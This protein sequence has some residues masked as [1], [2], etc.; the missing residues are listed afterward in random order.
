MMDSNGDVF[1]NCPFDHAYNPLFD[2][3][4]FTVYCCSFR[5]RCAYEAGDEDRLQR[6]CKIIEECDYGIHDLSRTELNPEGLPR[7]NM[8]LELGI[9]IGAKQYG[10]SHQKKKHYLILDTEKYRFHSFISDL[11][12]LDPKEHGNDPQKI[13]KRVRN[14]LNTHT[15]EKLLSAIAIQ[16]HYLEFLSQRNDLYEDR[17]LT[18]HDAEYS[19]ITSIMESWIEYTLS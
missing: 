17:E 3:I 6:I 15:A 8:P 19:D 12:G 5:P 10:G 11:G 18:E 2:S 9:F 1:I 7:F 13:I 14:W 4:L 16:R